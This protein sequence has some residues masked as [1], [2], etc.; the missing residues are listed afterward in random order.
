MLET[1]TGNFHFTTSAS[2]S[3]ITTTAVINQSNNH[4]LNK[5]ADNQLK[6]PTYYAKS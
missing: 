2:T 6:N 3:Y 5:S 4:M 1:R